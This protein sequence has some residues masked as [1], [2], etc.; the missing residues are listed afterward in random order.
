MKA[1][2]AVVSAVLEVALTRV[3]EDAASA[4]VAARVPAREGSPALLNTGGHDYGGDGGDGHMVSGG[5]GVS[6]WSSVFALHSFGRKRSGVGVVE[7]TTP[8]NP[9]QE[10]FRYSCFGRCFAGGASRRARHYRMLRS[11]VEAH[12]Q[13]TQRPESRLHAREELVWSSSYARV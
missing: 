13:R 7:S 4:A 1:R 5:D 6:G 3:R 2:C 11:R 10:R 12:R 8:P 9:V